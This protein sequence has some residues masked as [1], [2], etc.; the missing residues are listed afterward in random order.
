MA[1]LDPVQSALQ[2]AVDEGTF[3]GA[4]LAVR[5]RGTVVYEG[6]V[7]R[8]SS[9]APSEAVTVQTCYDLASLTKVLATTTALMAIRCLYCAFAPSVSPEKIGIKEIGSTTTKNTI[10]N[11]INC[12]IMMLCANYSDLKAKRSGSNMKPTLTDARAA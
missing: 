4:V 7:G 10:K 1:R 5:L 12:S 2:A 6:A 9:Q 8:L 11:L 3:P